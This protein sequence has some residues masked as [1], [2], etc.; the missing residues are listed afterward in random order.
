[1]AAALGRPLERDAVRGVAAEV[2][3]PGRLEQVGEDPPTYIDAA[4]N[5]EGMEALAAALPELSAGRPVVAYLAVMADKDAE[6][7]IA[8]VAPV[9]SAAITTEPPLDR[10]AMTRPGAAAHPAPDLAARLHGHGVEAEAVP[11]ARSAAVRAAELARERGGIVVAAGSHYGLRAV[12]EA[13]SV[14]PFRP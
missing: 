4:H 5:A 2:E 11:D 10:V 3:I 7:M 6:A 13:A 12:R 1:V 14:R 9:I 8:A